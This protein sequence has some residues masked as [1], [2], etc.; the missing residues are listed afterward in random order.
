MVRFMFRT[1]AVESSVIFEARVYFIFT[2]SCNLFLQPF[3]RETQ[4]CVR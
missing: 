1:T 2:T 4:P 3:N